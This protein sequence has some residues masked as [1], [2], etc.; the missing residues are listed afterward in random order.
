MPHTDERV[1]VPFI[2]HA[3][4]GPAAT[5]AVVLARL[6]ARVAFAGCAGD[7]RERSE[8]VE[9]L[10]AEGV[11][12]VVVAVPGASTPQSCALIPGDG[13]RSILTTAKASGLVGQAPALWEAAAPLLGAA[14]WAHLDH[15]GWPLWRHPAR[16]AHSARVSI[17]GGN[18]VEDLELSQVALYAPTRAELARRYGHGDLNLA[19]ATAHDQGAGIVVVTAGTEGCFVSD[20]RAPLAHVPAVPTTVVSTLGAGDAF[21]GGLVWGLAQDMSPVEAARLGSEVAAQAC[22]AWDGRSGVRRR[23]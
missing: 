11:L 21:H 6:G 1:E 15:V 5:A 17:D 18:P 7:D 12:A 9:E 19:V 4:G 22:L 20:G 8:L 16:P 23:P 2:A 3:G 14:R 10:Q 13:S